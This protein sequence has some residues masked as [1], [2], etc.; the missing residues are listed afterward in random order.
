M[1]KLVNDIRNNF[2]KNINNFNTD[3]SGVKKFDKNEG[4]Q[5]P[6][7]VGFTLRFN[8]NNN[9]YRNFPGGVTG[10]QS[11]M[12]GLL[13]SPTDIDSSYNFLIRRNK[14][15]N[16]LMLNEFIKQLK[17]IQDNK[18]W[19]FKSV[20]GLN[21]LMKKP[22]AGETWRTKDKIL[23][24]DCIESFDFQI[25]FLADLYRKATYDME[26]RRNLLPME[27]RWFNLDIIVT[28]IR[29]LF[30]VERILD[31]V[32][33]TDTSTVNKIFGGESVSELT[34]F[35][36]MSS[37]QQGAGYLNYD[38]QNTPKVAIPNRDE[39]GNI[40]SPESKE[41]T[42]NKY[43]TS[44]RKLNDLLTFY[45]FKL[46]DCE[47]IFDDYPFLETID[48]S[49][50]APEA[51][52]TKFQISVGDVSEY[53][54]YGYYEW[55][56]TESAIAVPETYENSLNLN[57]NEQNGIKPYGS[58]KNNW[59]YWTHPDDFGDL[60]LNSEKSKREANLE[61]QDKAVLDQQE[62]SG[63][64]FGGIEGLEIVKK[65][66]EQG[67][68]SVGR[69]L[70]ILRDKYIRKSGINTNI[71]GDVTRIASDIDNLSLANPMLGLDIVNRTKQLVDKIKDKKDSDTFK[72][73]GKK[74]FDEI[75]YP[76]NSTLAKKNSNDLMYVSLR[77][78]KTID[79]TF[80]GFKNIGDGTIYDY[81][82]DILSNINQ[83][84]KDY[85]NKKM[86]V[87]LWKTYTPQESRHPGTFP[88]IDNKGAILD[89]RLNVFSLNEVDKN[90]DVTNLEKIIQDTN[91]NISSLDYIPTEKN[92][93]LS[94][95]DLN[96]QDI[97]KTIT[98][99]DLTSP[100]KKDTITDADLNS[101]EK[102]DSITDFDLN[103]PVKKD[104][105]TEADLNAP[106]KKDTI[107]DAELVSPVKKDTI[108]DA[109]LNSPEKKDT[110]T[111]AEL[112]S[113]EKK[114]SITGV[115]LN[116]PMKKDTITGVELN[117]SEKNISITDVAFDTS[118]TKNTITG[119][120][121]NEFDKKN[122]ITDVE[123]VSTNVNSQIQNI[124]FSKNSV[125][126]KVQ[127][128][129]L[130]SPIKITELSNKSMNFTLQSKK[131]SIQP[132]KFEK[133]EKK[134]DIS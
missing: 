12:T 72:L 92:Q 28:E 91:K 103:A 65:F 131:T 4:L 108:T 118:K 6:T 53:N 101:P 63:Q 11:V 19:Y 52:S 39:N 106:V 120:D 104:S 98:N 10:T 124:E 34:G 79:P 48:N 15:K 31:E 41:Q 114:N 116:A 130:I 60:E 69:E 64:M 102:K 129:E 71:I 133:K 95:F 70:N 111:N 93:N 47:F 56:L 123:L 87:P 3:P 23:T 126:N 2:L 40:E 110:I 115:D 16:A 7:Y 25:N 78:E 99:L 18:Q 46:Y 81:G 86:L 66:K 105:I 36:A 73:Q 55:I 68:S 58:V 27:K 94:Q 67:Q 45:I 117:T 90:K 84:R 24:I 97:N 37:V 30:E 121:L 85:L 76:S 125:K 127:N 42:K 82:D 57:W 77:K 32:S 107:T 100:I 35:S 128:L 22:L 89:G 21:E 83:K 29:N 1:S 59:Q 33:S 9:D 122:T 43:K 51:I 112:N 113:P 109:E 20:N 74:A 61:K 8:F 13:L 5:D 38:F 132:L 17:N 134:S 62:A 44:F 54:Q 50:I 14:A 80:N 49:N 75:I 119:V 88:N 26:F 96:K